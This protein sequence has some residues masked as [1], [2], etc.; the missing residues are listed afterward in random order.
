MKQLAILILSS[1]LIQCQ[2]SKKESMPETDF[3]IS[4]HTITYKKQE[5]PFGKPVT[6][7]IKIFGKYSRIHHTTVYI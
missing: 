4:E 2:S 1:M 3:Y 7:W 5:P 6:E